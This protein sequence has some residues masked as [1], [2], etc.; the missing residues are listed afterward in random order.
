[1]IKPPDTHGRPQ[2]VATQYVIMYFY[3]HT[4][5]TRREV[6]EFV[7]DGCRTDNILKYLKGKGFIKNVSRGVWE[8]A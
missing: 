7:G 2:S 8:L 5:L 4:R 3:S 6:L 1:M